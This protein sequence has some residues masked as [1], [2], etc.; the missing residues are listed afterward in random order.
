MLEIDVVAKNSDEHVLLENS[1]ERSTLQEVPTCNSDD[2]VLAQKKRVRRKVE[3]KNHVDDVGTLSL[4]ENREN[5]SN[6]INLQANE[7]VISEYSGEDTLLCNNVSENAG[8]DPSSI[9]FS[10]PESVALPRVVLCLAHNGKVAWD[11]KWKPTN[12][13]DAKCKHRMGYLAVLLGNGSLEV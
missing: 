3:T 8:L 2:E 11:L 4:T 5:E 13:C 6:A 1:V 10:I 12:A 7:N 9:E